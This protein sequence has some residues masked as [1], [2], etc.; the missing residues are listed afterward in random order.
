MRAAGETRSEIGLL[1]DLLKKEADAASKWME[2]LELFSEVACRTLLAKQEERFVT[3]SRAHIQREIRKHFSKY[4]LLATP[5]RFLGEIIRTPFRLLGLWPEEK[6][7]GSEQD[8][9]EIFQTADLTMI[10]AAVESFNRSVL[11]KLSPQDQT[12]ALYGRL[13]DPNLVLTG[14]AIQQ[15]TKEE[16]DRLMRWLEETF[17]RLAQGIPK[18]KELGIYSTSILWGALIIALETAIGGGISLLEAVLNTAVA[19]FV[20]KGAVDLF[21]YHELQKIVRELGEHYQQALTASLRLQSK[22]YRRRSPGA[23]GVSPG[24][25]GT[26][27]G[28]EEHRTLGTVQKKLALILTLFFIHEVTRRE[29]ERNHFVFFVLKD[30]ALSYSTTYCSLVRPCSFARLARSQAPAWERRTRK[31]RL[32]VL[33][34][35]HVAATRPGSSSFQTVGSQARAWE[36]VPAFNA[37][38]GEILG[39]A[40]RKPT[41]PL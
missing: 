17:Q 33:L 30:D 3:E 34:Q 25:A 18:S 38:L 8:L 4:D 37:A 41:H 22:R 9:A 15:Q 26:C 31:L 12:S 7:P 2:Q 19:P 1:L 21:A 6:P 40:V 36:P 5:R 13:R 28:N 11:E 23:D 32:P 35:D 39:Q 16:Q 27:R 20:T 29:H 10:Q 24:V 14:E